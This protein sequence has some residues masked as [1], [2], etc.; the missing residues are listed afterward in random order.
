MAGDWI[1]RLKRR[2]DGRKYYYRHDYCTT[3]RKES[4]LQMDEAT[5][6]QLALAITTHHPDFYAWAVPYDVKH[7]KHRSEA[8]KA[9]KA[10]STAD[11]AAA[12]PASDSI[13]ANDSVGCTL[14]SPKSRK[15][16][17]EAK[18]K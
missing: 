2:R 1:M 10:A 14:V 8:V 13:V 9:A 5:A 18:A 11:A 7:A 4:S 17:K 16:T 15:D 6:K 3:A 12:K